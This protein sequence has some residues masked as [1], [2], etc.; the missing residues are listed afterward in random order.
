MHALTRA[1]FAAQEAA[2]SAPVDYRFQIDPDARGTPGAEQ[3]NADAPTPGRGS[4]E[5]RAP[6]PPP[7]LGQGVPHEG[8]AAGAGPGG[9]G[10]DGS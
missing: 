5:E 8:G 6:L 1:R 2:S 3:S 10:G 4:D 9:A 7:L